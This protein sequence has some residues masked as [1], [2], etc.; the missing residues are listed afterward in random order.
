[1]MINLLYEYCRENII[2]NSVI[3]SEYL[4]RVNIFFPIN[5]DRN[6]YRIYESIIFIIYFSIYTAITNVGDSLL[7]DNKP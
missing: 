1:M 4:D 2:Y 5:D 6:C 7:V 3:R